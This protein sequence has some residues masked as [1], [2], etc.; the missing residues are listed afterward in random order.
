MIVPARPFPAFGAFA[1]R[2]GG[3]PDRL[4]GGRFF[5]LGRD[6]LLYGLAQIGLRPGDALVFPAYYCESA[7]QPLRRH[8]FRLVFVDIDAE[9]QVPF[10]AVY[11]ELVSSRGRAVV[12]V[13][14][15]GFPARCNR[16]FVARCHE[17]GARVV[18]DRC[19]AVLSGHEGDCGADGIASSFRKTLAVQDGGY[20]KSTGEERG[21]PLGA[22]GLG[23]T[24][25]AMRLAERGAVRLGWPNP[26]GK[27][28]Q[29]FRPSSSRRVAEREVG[30]ARPVSPSFSLARYLGDA[31]FLEDV[32]DRRR[33]NYRQLVAALEGT[34][35]RCLFPQLPAGVVPQ[36]LPVVE[37]TGSLAD[38]LR[39]KGVGAFRWPGDEL[40]EEVASRPDLFP[41]ANAINRT[42]TC[43]PVHQDITGRHIRYIAEM[44][45]A[46]AKEEA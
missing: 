3:V 30:T 35:V 2:G 38:F 42:V 28:V 33:E 20:W 29:R 9:L 8:G 34:G 40:P 26:Y 15:F 23:L 43:L 10:E 46:W 4:R 19:H 16:D 32:V 1:F 13:D 11:G 37:E 12:L 14:F 39:G 44:V 21:Q 18:V 41:H 17:A 5:R 31:S 27:L 6:A 25:L 7:L 36:V 45:M 22:G 24:Y